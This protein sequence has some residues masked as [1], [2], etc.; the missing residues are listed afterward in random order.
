MNYLELLP[1]D[2]RFLIAEFV[3][4]KPDRPYPYIDE[5]KNVVLDWY[6]K[7]RV[8][9]D[10]VINDFQQLYKKG[11][12][13]IETKYICYGFKFYA[14]EIRYYTMKMCHRTGQF[15][16]DPVRKRSF[17]RYIRSQITNA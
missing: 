15:E 9:D 2:L 16:K 11:V 12:S 4:S 6:N 7:T 5:Y 13:D 17:T 14:R 3:P 1:R 10:R 8:Y